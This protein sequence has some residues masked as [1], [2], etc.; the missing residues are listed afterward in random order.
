VLYRA[1]PPIIAENSELQAKLLDRAAQWL[2]PGGSLVYSVCSLEPEEGEK[3]VRAFLQRN[4]EFQIEP[5]QEFPAFLP[6]SGEGWVRILP[7]LLESDG[8]IDGFFMARLV[9]RG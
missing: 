4:C 7:G 1:R 8:G 3:V 6:V 2:K 5:P 9:R